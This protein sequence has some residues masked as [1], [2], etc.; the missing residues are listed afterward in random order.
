MKCKYKE[1]FDKDGE[2]G[3]T[4]PDCMKYVIC[5]YEDKYHSYDARKETKNEDGER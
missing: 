3:L 5:A 2:C 4:Y 1:F